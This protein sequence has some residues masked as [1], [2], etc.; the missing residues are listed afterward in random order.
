MSSEQILGKC[1]QSSSP[2]WQ[3][4]NKLRRSL[5][6]TPS[7]W[8]TSTLNPTSEELYYLLGNFQDFEIYLLK[9]GEAIKYLANY[10]TKPRQSKQTI[11]AVP[12]QDPRGPKHH[13][14]ILGRLRWAAR[15]GA[16]TAAHYQPVWEHVDRSVLHST[17]V[18]EQVSISSAYNSSARALQATCC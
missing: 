3:E 12:E 2:K 5:N 11:A 18:L 9:P 13:L 14:G 6:T 1:N 10:V 4:V 8:N 17:A 15:W 7:S 16:W